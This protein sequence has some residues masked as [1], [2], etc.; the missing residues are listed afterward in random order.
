MG[1]AASENEELAIE[2]LAEKVR[3][4]LNQTKYRYAFGIHFDDEELILFSRLSFKDFKA[5]LKIQIPDYFKTESIKHNLVVGERPSISNE[6]LKINLKEL[7]EVKSFIIRFGLYDNSIKVNDIYDLLDKRAKLDLI[8]ISDSI[9]AK[10]AITDKEP[11]IRMAAFQRLGF[12]TMLSKMLEDPSARIRKKAVE[13]IP[14][15]DQR[16]DSLTLE[17][18]KFVFQ[19]IVRKIDKKNLPMLLA[20]RNIDDAEIKNVFNR[21]MANLE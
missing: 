20:N 14:M 16:L 15:G 10:K 18:S 12:I 4:H 21:R 1:S 8:F 2:R 13:L 6:I 3:S 17:K 9:I 19:D 7:D 5:R 11:D